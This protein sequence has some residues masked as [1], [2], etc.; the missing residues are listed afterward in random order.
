MKSMAADRSLGCPFVSIVCSLAAVAWLTVF[1]LSVDEA[2]LE[3]IEE[4][5]FKIDPRLLKKMQIHVE[6]EQI[7]DEETGEVIEKRV[8]KKEITHG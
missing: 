7:V 3:E 8:K 4:S 1:V 6:H 2:K 5:P